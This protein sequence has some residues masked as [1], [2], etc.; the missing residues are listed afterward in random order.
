MRGS[1]QEVCW[2]ILTSTPR[3]PAF[4]EFKSCAQ[5]QITMPYYSNDYTYARRY[6]TPYWNNI[7]HTKLYHAD[8]WLFR[9]RRWYNNLKSAANEIVRSNGNPDPYYWVRQD[10]MGTNGTRSLAVRRR[11]AALSARR[12]TYVPKRKTYDKAQKN[13]SFARRSKAYFWRTRR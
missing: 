4:F 2:V 9:K 1:E 3:S 8:Y 13:R 5:V 10:A 7:A 11:Y 12:K 6:W